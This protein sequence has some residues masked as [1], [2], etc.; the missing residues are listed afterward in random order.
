MFFFLWDTATTD[1]HT[2]L[3][4]LSLHDARPILLHRGAPLRYRRD[5]EILMR[6]MSLGTLRAA[7][8]PAKAIAGAVLLT[9]AGCAPGQA[10]AGAA[11]HGETAMEKKLFAAG[12]QRFTFSDWAGPAMPVW[13]Y[14]APG[15]P[16]DAPI[17]R[18]EEHTS[19]L[20]SLMRISYAVFCL[21]K[22]KK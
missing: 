4:T 8:G 14:R 13:T 7:T 20:Q 5:G 2:N 1:I 15:T 10:V 3:P 18:S 22:K 9:L 17:L 19:E 12:V 21:K 16:A 6:G 11:P